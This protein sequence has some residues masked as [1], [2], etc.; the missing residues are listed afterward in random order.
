VK[1]I[2]YFKEK[3][4]DLAISLWSEDEKTALMRIVHGVY[5]ADNEFD[6]LEKEYFLE[7]LDTLRVDARAVDEMQM[8]DAFE[9]LAGDKLKNKLVYV[10]M[11]DAVFKDDDY[12]ALEKS[13]IELMN[14]RYPLEEA[15]LDDAIKAV[16][17]KKL[18]IVLK[19]WVKEIQDTRL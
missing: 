2:D 8:S 9:V 6:K 15:M 5:V 13:Y 4:D 1:F 3:F 11:A 12:D 16:R 14:Q 19:E 18:E 10:L 7:K 17:D